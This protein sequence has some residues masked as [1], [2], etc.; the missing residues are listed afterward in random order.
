MQL[1]VNS[2]Q[3]HMLT[4]FALYLLLPYA[5]GFSSFSTAFHIRSLLLSSCCKS[6]TC[7]P[8]SACFFHSLFNAVSNNLFFSMS[9]LLCCIS[10]FSTILSDW[11]CSSPGSMLSSVSFMLSHFVAESYI[12]EIR[13]PYVHFLNS[14]FAFNRTVL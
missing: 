5:N 2:R 6:T 11:I 12:K 3:L 4:S 8:S 9:V 1:L 7:S 10:A 14:Y 13:K